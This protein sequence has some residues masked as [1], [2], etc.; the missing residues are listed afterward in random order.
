[1]LSESNTESSIYTPS[2]SEP[3]RKTLE[4]SENQQN[5][6]DKSSSDN[7]N[8]NTHFAYIIDITKTSNSYSN[9][10]KKY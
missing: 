1:M 4:I 5:E 7:L 8:E 10:I 9:L 6:P 3:E 2:Y